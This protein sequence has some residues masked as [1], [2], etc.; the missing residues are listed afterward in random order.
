[1]T[2]LARFVVAALWCIGVAGCQA[3]PSPTVPP[4]APTILP[5]VAPPP[6]I[7]ATLAWMLEHTMTCTERPA[8]AGSRAW[9][10]VGESHWDADTFDKLSV[11]ITRDAHGA[12]HLVGVL[13]A[14]LTFGKEP[15]PGQVC[16]VYTGFFADTIALSPITGQDGPAVG[17]WI[18]KNRQ[19]GGPQQVG[20]IAVDYR[21]VRPIFT[22][23]LDLPAAP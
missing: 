3:T 10:C 14:T 5:T 1:M 7:Q 18:E 22:L 6:D 16:D 21:P 23:T 9:E 11:T 20:Q 17:A 15:C 2:R 19:A 4:P 13:D 8:D 12:T